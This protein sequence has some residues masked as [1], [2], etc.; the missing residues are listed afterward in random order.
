M[1]CNF[2]N[3]AVQS[4]VGLAAADAYAKILLSHHEA[5]HVSVYKYSSPPPLQQRIIITPSEQSLIDLALVLRK[6]THLPFWNA[7]FTA[8]IKS[9]S[10]SRELIEAAFFH[11]GPGEPHAYDRTAIESGTLEALARSGQKNLGLSSLVHDNHHR[12]WHLPLLDFHCDI[13]PMNEALAALICSHLMPGGYVLIDSG[14]SYHACGLTLLSPH[15]RVQMLGRALLATPVV[16]GHYIAHQ[17]QQDA[18]SIRI[19]L[20]GKAS[21]AP[22]VIRAWTPAEDAYALRDLGQVSV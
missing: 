9:Q 17:L 8:C 14:D 7:L 21:H 22:I 2:H 6:D 16:D 13:S 3:S 1:A 10:H 15:E 19:S 11:N 4:L 5:Q 20:G 18:S 12:S